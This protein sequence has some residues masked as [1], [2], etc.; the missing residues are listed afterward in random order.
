MLSGNC[1][2]AQRWLAA[3]SRNQPDVL[4]DK[5]PSRNL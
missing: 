4:P 3:P 1:K 2:I 5:P